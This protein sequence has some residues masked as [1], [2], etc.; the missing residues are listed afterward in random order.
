MKVGD[1]VTPKDYC[2]NSGRLAVIVEAPAESWRLDCVKIMYPDTCE[3]GIAKI[4]N[5]EVVCENR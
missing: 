1:L 2:K 5:L 3:R 4:A